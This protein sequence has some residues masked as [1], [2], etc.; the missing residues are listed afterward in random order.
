MNEEIG[1]EEVNIRILKPFKKFYNMAMKVVLTYGFKNLLSVN[2]E[3]F[4]E[5]LE[6]FLKDIWTP[7]L[8]RPAE[9]FLHWCR[10]VL[11]KS[12]NANQALLFEQVKYKIEEAWIK[13]II[14]KAKVFKRVKVDID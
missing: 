9:I 13:T 8:K 3:D 14:M 10:D 2:Q 12:S 5:V 1:I 7:N 4:I 11:F 6:E